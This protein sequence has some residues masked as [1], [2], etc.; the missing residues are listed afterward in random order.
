M[1]QLF[2]DL[3]CEIDTSPELRTRRDAVAAGDHGAD[4]RVHD[5]LLLLDGRVFVPASSTV[6]DDILQL[7]HTGG[8]EGIQ[9]TL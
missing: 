5:G 2:E 6:L 3:R 1:F 7:A 4:W 9:K 8:H